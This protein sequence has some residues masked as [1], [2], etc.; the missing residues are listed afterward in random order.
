MQTKCNH[1]KAGLDQYLYIMMM[2]TLIIDMATV[3]IHRYYSDATLII[4]MA[5]IMI[6]RWYSDAD[7]DHRYGNNH[8]SLLV[9]RCQP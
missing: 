5:T 8:V 1:D 6:H 3:M 9:F 4:D 2:P 7:L